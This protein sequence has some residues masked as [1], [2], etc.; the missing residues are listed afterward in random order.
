MIVKR[1]DADVEYD[2]GGA[3]PCMCETADGDYVKAEDYDA[4]AA[5][6][7]QDRLLRRLDC[8][9]SEACCQCNDL[10]DNNELLHQR[11]RALD[12]DYIDLAEISERLQ[13][14]LAE[15]ERWI[16][17]SRGDYPNAA[18]YVDEQIRRKDAALTVNQ[19]AA[20]AEGKP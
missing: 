17:Q 11:I 5:E 19:R 10:R 1:Y 2:F 13:A 8:E 14:R 18:R 16:A 9:M 7:V 20:S 4:L 12:A 6:L 3:R 15:A